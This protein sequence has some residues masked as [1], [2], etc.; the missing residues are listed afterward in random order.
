MPL[1]T[2]VLGIGK[3]VSGVVSA[4]AKGLTV[5][6]KAT[7][8]GISATGKVVGK[9][10]S[11]TGKAARASGRAIGKARRSTARGLQKAVKSTKRRMLNFFKGRYNK[12]TD[13]DNIKKIKRNSN[14][15]KS[16]LIQ[17]IKKIKK[18]RLDRERIERNVLE[19]KEIRNMER[20]IR[21][22]KTPT[23]KKVQ[24]ILKS[25]MNIFDKILGLGGILLTGIVVNA[26]DDIIEKFKEFKENNQGLFDNIAKILT[27]IKDS[28]VFIFDSITKPFEE[29]G[30]FDGIAKFDDNGNLQDG[31]LKELE[32]AIKK[33]Q[34][35]VD[36]INNLRK[37]NKQIDENRRNRKPFDPNTTIIKEEVD[38]DTGE[39]KKLTANEFNKKT[40][41]IDQNGTVRFKKNDVPAV[42]W[43]MSATEEDKKILDRKNF[44]KNKISKINNVNMIKNNLNF[45]NTN[46]YENSII[47]A[48]QREIEY[49]P[50][51]MNF[52]SKNDKL[53]NINHLNEIKLPSIWTTD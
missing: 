32:N 3:V 5:A 24:S 35:I 34:P 25:P 52:E 13:A 46:S 7:A 40:Y 36:V 21:S 26:I 12:K 47:F 15:I 4:T 22:S 51:N 9:A 1:P 43:N 17:N 2:V 28:F 41:Y 20:N 8:K 42:L 50:L 18:Q 6:G 19:R 38:E 53:F 48:Y 23:G 37:G 29:E 10:A 31:K 39:I 14:K 49:V 16:K 33:L 45:L 11:A 44:N 27:V 30:S